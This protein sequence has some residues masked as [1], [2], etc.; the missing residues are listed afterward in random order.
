ML[1]VLS[2]YLLSWI[3]QNIWHILLGCFPF[4]SFQ[5]SLIIIYNIYYLS[6]FCFYFSYALEIHMFNRW[7][8]SSVPF[9][10]SLFSF[11]WAS[12]VLFKELSTVFFLEFISIW[13]PAKKILLISK[14]LY[15][16]IIVE[17]NLCFTSVSLLHHLVNSYFLWSLFSTFIFWVFKCLIQDF[18]GNIYKS[19]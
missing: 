14:Y 5:C 16:C 10:S 12:F 6:L 15:F 7:Y 18:F 9:F 13:Y 8:L 3:V 1:T 19:F 17:V 2:I 11:F 4:V